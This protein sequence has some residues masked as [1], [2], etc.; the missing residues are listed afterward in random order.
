MSKDVPFSFCTLKCHPSDNF[1]PSE[2]KTIDVVWTLV[3]CEDTDHYIICTL[4]ATS[5]L[6]L[7]NLMKDGNKPATVRSSLTSSSPPSVSPCHTAVGLVGKLLLCCICCIKETLL[8][9]ITYQY[10]C[11]HV[12]SRNMTA[13]DVVFMKYACIIALAW[14]PEFITCI[15]MRDTAE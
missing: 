3:L 9:W 13:P 7:S 8:S 5:K 2:D 11:M 10:Q 15:Q 14:H 12:E 4:T 6:S 1:V